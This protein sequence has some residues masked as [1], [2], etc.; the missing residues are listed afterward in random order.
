MDQLTRDTEQ[1]LET[2][3]RMLATTAGFDGTVNGTTVDELVQMIS[4]YNSTIAALVSTAQHLLGD[5]MTDRVEAHDIWANISALETHVQELLGNASLAKNTTDAVESLLGQ[6]EQ[7]R[8]D[9]RRNLTRLSEVV[10]D[11]RRE[12]RL[13]NSS[14]VNVSRDTAVANSSVVDLES[15]L[16]YLRS[17]TNVV[18]SLTRQLNGSIESA[19]QASQNLVENT[20]NIL[21]GL[22]LTLTHTHTPES[23]K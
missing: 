14:L 17:H 22:T 15:Q 1:Q 12:L 2:A 11:L 13:V 5:L 21:V 7:Q 19:R 23:V 10:M 9:L 3:E 18:L 20:I 6:L 4:D 16:N 8:V